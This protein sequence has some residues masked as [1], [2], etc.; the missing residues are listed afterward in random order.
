MANAFFDPDDFEI[1][2]PVAAPVDA[3][4]VTTKVQEE[5]PKFFD[6]KPV[7]PAPSIVAASLATP[8]PA[9]EP[10]R[11]QRVGALGVVQRVVDHADAAAFPNEPAAT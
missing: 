5:K 6:L 9:A 11:R 10:E 7:A 2:A 1:P 4:P 8:Q 3:Q